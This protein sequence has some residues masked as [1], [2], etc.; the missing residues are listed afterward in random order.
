MIRALLLLSVL[1]WMPDAAMAQQASPQPL[2][3]LLENRQA[4]GLTPPQVTQIENLRTGLTQRNEPLIAR[5]VELRAQWQ[6]EQ[7]ALRRQGGRQGQALQQ[8][9]PPLLGTGAQPTPGL[10]A[11]RLSAQ[12]LRTQIDENNR[13]AMQEVNRLLDRRQKARLREL[14]QARRPGGP[15]GAGGGAGA[16]R[17]RP[18]A[19]LGD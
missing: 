17:L 5:F 10:E 1:G 2:E 13:S 4:L 6:R 7:R 11:I 15:G 18:P 12:T 14:V 3:I 9:L 16:A 8:Q 19:V